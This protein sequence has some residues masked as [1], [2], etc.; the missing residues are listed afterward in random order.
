MYRRTWHL[1][2]SEVYIGLSDVSLG[3]RD[4]L[5]SLWR[6]GSDFGVLWRKDTV[7]IMGEN[8]VVFVSTRT[9]RFSVSRTCWARRGLRRTRYPRGVS[10]FWP[11]FVPG[12]IPVSGE[13]RRFNET[14][15]GRGT[16]E[17]VGRTHGKDLPEVEIPLFL[18]FLSQRALVSSVDTVKRGQFTL[19]VSRPPLNKTGS[20]R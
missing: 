14:G 8:T 13:T 18:R 16:V 2:I 10:S 4:S 3:L 17:R 12:S 7:K 19:L 6:G 9:E 15:R 20:P 5:K 1:I 11:P